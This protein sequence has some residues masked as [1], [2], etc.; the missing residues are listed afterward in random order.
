M[1][2]TIPKLT[3]A[4]RSPLIDLIPGQITHRVVVG[5]NTNV[6]TLADEIKMNVTNQ[7]CDL[8]IA[9]KATDE[10]CITSL[11]SDLVTPSGPGISK[12]TLCKT[13]QEMAPSRVDIDGY[14]R[15]GK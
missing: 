1:A 13:V 9:I 6:F 4:I 12:T 5:P 11:L 2:L 7:E 10:I 15:M 14:V 8:P 3:Y